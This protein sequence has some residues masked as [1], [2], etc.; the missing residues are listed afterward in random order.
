MLHGSRKPTLQEE[1]LA[2]FSIELQHQIQLELEWIPREENKFAN[3]LSRLC[4]PDDWMLNP[5]V[6]HELDARWDPHTVDR[7]ADVHNSHLRRFN[8]RYWSPGT[9]AVDTLLVIE[10]RI[11]IGGALLCTLPDWLSMQR[12]PELRVP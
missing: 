1:A 4:D 5:D 10:E 11:I 8:S 3:Y 7:F 6:F 2:I 12:P 9:E